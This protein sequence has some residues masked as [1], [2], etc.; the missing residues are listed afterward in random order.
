[1]ELSKEE[2]STDEDQTLSSIHILKKLAE[3]TAIVS[4]LLWV[5]KCGLGIFSANLPFFPDY[6]EAQNSFG[7]KTE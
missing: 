3:E 7:A 6:H 1:M 4:Y 5:K 2:E